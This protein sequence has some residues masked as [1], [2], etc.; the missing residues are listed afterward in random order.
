VTLM[1]MC[2]HCQIDGPDTPGGLGAERLAQ[3]EGWAV[4]KNGHWCPDC[5]HWATGLPTSNQPGAA[6]FEL[7]AAF[8][9][10]S[11]AQAASSAASTLAPG[12]SG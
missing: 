10:W 9:R 2:D 11:A 8:Q 1:V 3:I 7:I 12:E 5:A 6:D 4:T